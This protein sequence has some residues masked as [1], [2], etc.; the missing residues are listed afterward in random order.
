MSER[1]VYIAIVFLLISCQSHENGTQNKSSSEE[2]SNPK[3]QVTNTFESYFKSDT[4][5]VKRDSVDLLT[6]SNGKKKDE[7]LAICNCDKNVRENAITIQISV[8][9]PTNAELEEEATGGRTFMGLTKSPKK[10]QFRY[11]TFHLKDST[12]EK[13]RLFYKALKKVYNNTDFK[14]SNISKHQIK[15]SKFDYSIASEVFGNFE[16]VLPEAFGYF[17]NDTLLLGTFHCNNWR[18]QSLEEVKK[19]NLESFF[20]N[21]S[22][23][24]E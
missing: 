7:I 9:I 13:T 1:L 18:V 10:A 6:I 8:A 11:L 19:W 20:K 24:I 3:L 16:V 5:L 2:I 4:T 12:V 15:I 21:N 23:P 14:Y 17:K 22:G